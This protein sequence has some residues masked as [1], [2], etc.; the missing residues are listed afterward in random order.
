MIFDIQIIQRGFQPLEATHNHGWFSFSGYDWPDYPPETWASEWYRLFES[1][2]VRSEL[3]WRNRFADIQDL[4]DV[5]NFYSSTEDV[6]RMDDEIGLLSAVEINVKW[7]MHFLPTDYDLTTPHVW[8]IQEMYK[9][10]DQLPLINAPGGGISKYAGW[11][12]TSDGDS[13]HIRELFKIFD[14][15]PRKPRTYFEKLEDTPENEDTRNAF[16]EDL[17]TEPLFRPNPS[18]LFKSGA[19]TFVNGTIG[20]NGGNLEYNVGDNGLDISQVKIRD[21]LLSKAFPARTRPMGSTVNTK[22]H[23]TKGNF[24]MSD[25]NSTKTFMTDPG[26]WYEPDHKYNGIIAWYHG[27]I[28]DAPYVHVYKLFEK[29]TTKEESP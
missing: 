4:T 21:Y 27:D 10:L 22:W 7:T 18:E 17:K 3:T 15:G 26:A 25:P 6:L 24:D 19:E 9:G 5:F 28:K 14:L 23:L 20:A 29:I 16:R 13:Y 1:S 2:D 12:F 11:G 8:Q